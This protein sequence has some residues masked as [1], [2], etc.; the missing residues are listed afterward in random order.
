M[1][2][3]KSVRRYIGDR[4]IILNCAGAVIVREGK[5][6]LQRRMDNGKWGLP[7]GLLDLDE[8][9][10][11]AAIREV[12]EETGLDIRLECLLGIFHNH[13]MVWS[14]GDQAHTIGAY[15]LA[16]IASGELRTDDESYELRFFDR[17]ELPELFAP[18][19]ILAIE[20]YY[21]GVRSPLLKENGKDDG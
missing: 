10:E 1:E 8:T 21:N 6:L 14:N 18:D 9:Y 11:E 3:V 2:Y 13:D 4:K 20:A 17:D 7:G 16:S 12:R 5:I 15:Y 19:H